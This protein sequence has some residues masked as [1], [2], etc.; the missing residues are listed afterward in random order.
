MKSPD[1]EKQKPAFWAGSLNSGARTRTNAAGVEQ[2]ACRAGP[3][4]VSRCAANNRTEFDEESGCRK[5]KNRL[6]GGFGALNRN[7]PTPSTKFLKLL[8]DCL[9]LRQ[10]CVQRRVLA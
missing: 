1:V 4:G 3:E 5:A 9:S 10:F 2:R 7:P 6:L 8:I